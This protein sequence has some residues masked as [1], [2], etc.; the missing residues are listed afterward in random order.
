MQR[1]YAVVLHDNIT[2]ELGA[3]GTVLIRTPKD[4]PPYLLCEN[5]TPDGSLFGCTAWPKD[6]TEGATV[7]LLFPH[8]WVKFTFSVDNTPEGIGFLG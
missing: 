8:A 7:D 4:S 1:Q 2:K 3:V 6:R 5:I